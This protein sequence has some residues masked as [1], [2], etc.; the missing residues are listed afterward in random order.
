MNLRNKVY[1]LISRDYGKRFIVNHYYDK[2]QPLPIWAIFELISLGEFGTLVDCLELNTAKKVSKSVGIKVTYDRDGKLLPLIVYALKDLRNAVAHNNTIFDT[3]FKTSKVNLRIAKCISAETGINNITFESIVD[4]VVLISFMMKLL[5]CPKKK[6]LAFIRLFEK[7]CEELRGKVSTSI[8]NTIVYT[9]TRNK[10][11]LLRKYYYIGGMPEVVEEYLKNENFELV[12]IKQ[13]SILDSYF[14]DMGKYNK[15]TEIPKTKL[16]YKNIS[17]QLAKEN[18]KFKYSSIKSGG[19][20]SEF[21]S[22]IEWLCLARIA[23]QLYRV[24][25]IKIPLNSY[26]SLDDFKFYMNDVGL[27][28]ASQ[29]IL[30]DDILFD[31][32]DFG[33]FK[34]G[35]TENYVNNQL[36]INKHNCFY[37]TSGN[38]AEIDFIVRL[39]KDIIPLEVKSSDNTRSRSLNEYM[40]KFSPQYAIRIST[41][42]FGF[43][44]NIK[45]VPL[46]AVFCIK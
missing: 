7:N 17:T 21:A 24:E 4:Y 12:K 28:T 3:R 30:I 5:E 31:N 1:S 39:D 46:Y 41:K 23:N 19:R 40:I 45:S 6:I 10:L 35:L 26:K 20:A 33:D 29:D 2:D 18:R 15:E 34:G 43:E 11:D 22:A 16:V 42:N 25:Q 36:I 38:Q 13:Q 8:F 32:S 27:C 44:N 9:D 14:N 37:W